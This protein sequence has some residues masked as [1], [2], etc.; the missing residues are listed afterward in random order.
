MVGHTMEVWPTIGSMTAEEQNGFGKM[1][2]T[3]SPVSHVKFHVTSVHKFIFWYGKLSML[4]MRIVQLQ[5]CYTC[6][7]K[8]SLKPL[9]SCS[10]ICASVSKQYNLV[11]VEGR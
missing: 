7:D 9:A 8:A 10:H 1:E 3:V 11:L 6:L 2:G 5:C 4:G